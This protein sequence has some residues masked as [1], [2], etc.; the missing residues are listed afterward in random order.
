MIMLVTFSLLLPQTLNHEQETEEY[1][2]IYHH[3][4]IGETMTN[5]YLLV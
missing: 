5:L 3:G 4:A 2:E 1:L